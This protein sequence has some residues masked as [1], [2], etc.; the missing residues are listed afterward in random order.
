MPSAREFALEVLARPLSLVATRAFDV[1]GVVQRGHGTDLGQPV[2]VER[3]GARGA[4]NRR[5]PRL[6][7]P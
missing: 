5:V 7:T 4:G 1:L 2:H 3:D 6:P